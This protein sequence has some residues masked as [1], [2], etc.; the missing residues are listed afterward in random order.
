[1]SSKDNKFIQNDPIWAQN[2]PKG[3]QM[4]KPK[5]AEK[6][7]NELK[8]ALMSSNFNNILTNDAYLM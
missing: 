8:R 5:P 2:S 4:S 1:M 7:L 3:A 6:S